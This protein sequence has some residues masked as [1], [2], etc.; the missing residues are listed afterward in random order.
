MVVNEER[1]DREMSAL[2]RSSRY[3]DWREAVESTGGCASPVWLRGRHRVTHNAT[4]AVLHERAGQIA[5]PCGTRREGLCEPCSR[6]YTAD[7]FHLIRA[8]L[9]GDDS[10][11]VPAGV[12]GAPRL[13]VT[14]TAPSFGKVHTRPET[15]SGYVRPCAC[16]IRHS[17]TD[18]RLGQAIDPDTYDYIG[19]V[20]W[21]A[22][23]GDLWHR[24][25]IAVGRHLAAVGGIRTRELH[26]HVRLSYSKV[27]EFQRRGL[28]HFHAVIRL[29]GA[30]GAGSS[31]PD[32]ATPDALERAVTQAAECVSVEVALP[33][34]GCL[35][36]QWG[37]IDVREISTDSTDDTSD[38][39]L[40]G[41]IAKYATKSSG[42]T[43]SGIDRRFGDRSA[44]EAW[45]GSSHHQ[46]MMLTA[47]D[48]GEL[49]EYEYLHLKRVAHMLGFR[50]H[51]LTKSRAYSTTFKA[52]RAARQLHRLAELLDRLDV[53][54]DDVT[55]V[56]DWHMTSVG[57]ESDAEREM[58]SVIADRKLHQSTTMESTRE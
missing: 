25:R 2:I 30:A 46:A 54:A 8:G 4:G 40:A 14:L 50:G 12:A 37:R 43:D 7:A 36:V 9:T 15:A 41:Y 52:L 27:A 17:E 24:F 35:D 57:H 33:T 49:P 51:F 10:K 22:H 39:R 56:N 34:G 58:A 1:L 16:G 11:N 19:A 29:D 42:A 55:V 21:Q 6:R 47:W 44:I 31:T 32:W 3:R 13:F 45:R 23:V 53:A 5:V 20:L 48:L 18:T 26:D 38:A 28:V